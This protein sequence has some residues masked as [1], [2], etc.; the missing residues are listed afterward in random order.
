MQHDIFLSAKD[1]SDRN[2]RRCSEN[3]NFGTRNSR[4]TRKKGVTQSDLY[5]MVS[6]ALKEMYGSASRVSKYFEAP[7]GP[8]AFEIISGFEG[9]EKITITAIEIPFWSFNNFN[10]LDNELHSPRLKQI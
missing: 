9:R 5:Q 2:Y 4:V 6:Y 7:N 8:D 3:I 10:G 1:G